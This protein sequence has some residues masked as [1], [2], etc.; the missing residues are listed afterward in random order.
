MRSL[1]KASCKLALCALAAIPLAAQPTVT[2]LYS[3][4]AQTNCPDGQG[5][6]ELAQAMNGSF[7]GSTSEGGANYCPDLGCGTIFKITPGGNLTTLRSFCAQ[8]GCPDGESPGGM[9][10]ATNGDLYGTTQ[11]GGANLD[12]GPLGKGG[13]TV[14]KISPSGELTTL[15][16]FC[17]LPLCSDGATPNPILV[18]AANGDLYG[19]TS[20]GGAENFGTVFKI[21]PA[22]TLAT[23]HSF[24]SVSSCADGQYPVGGLV[25]AFNGDLYGTTWEGGGFTADGAPLVGTVF[26]ITPSGTLTTLHAF[27]SGECTDGAY[28]TG[29]VQAANGDFYGVTQSGGT[30]LGGFPLGLAGTLYKITANGTLTTLY[31]FCAQTN[32]LDGVQPNGPLVAATDGNL[33]GLTMYGGSNGNS[34]S[35]FKITP[36]GALTTLYNFCA[37]A[38]C[39]D[40]ALPSTGLVQATNGDFYGTTSEG[41]ASAQ[42]G[43]TVFRLSVGLA[44]FVKVQ[45]SIAIPGELV[46]ILGS[47]LTGATGVSFNGVS[48]K[49]EA[50]GSTLIIAQ[51]PMGASSGTVKVVTP[52]GTLKSNMPFEVIL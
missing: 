44:P 22:G 20:Q 41:G 40:G 27:C 24:C 12:V 21:T 48:A 25:Q 28:P 36:S 23:L 7:Y 33:Y 17:S 31:N 45:P 52:G 47:D 29:L 26:K 1:F 6:G 32:C 39:A 11:E 43:G 16:S 38:H 13:G 35:A 2:T 50:V 19:T 14:F 34:G 3:F 30:H 49:F 4:C 18:Q 42:E 5:P 15:Y 9:V 51:V 37:Q 8:N 10:Q 46:E